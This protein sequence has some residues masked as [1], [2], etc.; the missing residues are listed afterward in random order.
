MRITASVIIITCL[1]IIFTPLSVAA[2]EH[3]LTD[4]LTYHYDNSRTG[5]NNKETIL[6]PAK[7][8]DGTFGLLYNVADFDEQLDAQ[9]LVLANFP[10][11]GERK[12]IIIVA[13]EYN[14]LY[15]LDGDTGAK[16]GIRS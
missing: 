11:Y 3:Q 16:L 2:A 9:P 1:T 5:W 7:V 12:N 8:K 14:T 13:S 6:T 4:V 10:V 15:A